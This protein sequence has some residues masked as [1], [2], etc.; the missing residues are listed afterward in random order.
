M[1]A[2]FVIDYWLE[3]SSGR[4]ILLFDTFASVFSG[5]RETPGNKKPGTETGFFCEA[6]IKLLDF[7]FFVD[8]VLTNNWIK[9][10]DFHLFWHGA[11]VLV[12][13]VEMTSTSRRVQTNFFAHDYSS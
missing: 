10:F 13:G 2:A 3:C 9:L 1:P 12:S 11:L 7:A 5:G 8:H 6:N 4:Q